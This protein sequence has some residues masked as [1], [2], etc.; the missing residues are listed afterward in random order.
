MSERIEKLK[1]QQQQ[2][3]ARPDERKSK[4]SKLEAGGVLAASEESVGYRPRTRESRIAYEELLTFI[5]GHIG[6][7]PQDVLRGAAEEVLA[8]LKDDGMRDVDR[9]REVGK[10]LPRLGAEAYNRLVNLVR[11][12]NDFNVTV[13][14]VLT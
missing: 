4:K 9:Q 13:E 5:S 1:R 10:L 2:S 8:I 14:P 6:D 7:Q 11:R 12:I 3:E